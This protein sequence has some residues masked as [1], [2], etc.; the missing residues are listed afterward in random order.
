MVQVGHVLW[1]MLLFTS[2]PFLQ[3]TCLVCHTESR[4]L[5]PIL[6]ELLALDNKPGRSDDQLAKPQR[7]LY[8]CSFRLAIPDSLEKIEV[9]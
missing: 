8:N 1:Y 2:P 4:K 6:G 3:V 7:R 9:P 5:D